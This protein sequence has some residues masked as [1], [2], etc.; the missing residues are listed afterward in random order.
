MTNDQKHFI[1]FAAVIFVIVIAVSQIFFSTFF[2]TKDFP[3]RI[4]S[5]CIV[6]LA[7]C[8]S[9][10]WVMKTI[11]EKPKA[12][13]SVFTLQTTIKLLLYMAYIIVYLLIYRQH[14]IPFTVHFLIAYLVFT[15]FEVIS[16]LKFIRKNPGQMPGNV[17]KSN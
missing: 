11:I 6:W 2:E 10:F 4:I 7:T 9:H 1:L 15:L 3:L 12:F 17:K 13:V 16:I 8:A 5:V 14:V